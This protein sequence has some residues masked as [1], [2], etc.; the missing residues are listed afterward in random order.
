MAKLSASSVTVSFSSGCTPVG[1]SALF[2]RSQYGGRFWWSDDQGQVVFLHGWGANDSAYA[3]SSPDIRSFQ[4][5][6]RAIS[7]DPFHEGNLLAA[8]TTNLRRARASSPA[9]HIS[10][11][12]SVQ[13]WLSAISLYDKQKITRNEMVGVDFNT[14]TFTHSIRFSYL[15]FQNQI[16]DATTGNSSLPFDNL[17]AEIFMGATGLVAGPNLLAPQSTPQSDHEFKYDGSRIWGA[18]IIRFGVAYNHLHGGGF[19]SFFRNGPQIGTAVLPS[20]VDDRSD[21]ACFPGGAANPFNYPADFATLTNELGYSFTDPALGFPAGGLGPDN[22]VLLYLGDTWKIKSNFSLTYGLRY[23]RDTGRT[24]SQFPAIPQ[25]SALIPGLG[26]PVSQPNTNFAPQVGFAW[27]PTKSGKTSIRGGIGLFFEN[28]IW[29]N[30]LFDGPPRE[31]TGA[32]LQFFG[33]CSAPGQ[34]VQLQTVNGPINTQGSAS[35]TAICGPQGASTY[36]LIGNAVAPLSLFSSNLPLVL[37]STCR[38][39]IRPTLDNT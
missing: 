39:R 4:A 1:R 34:P 5:P 23:E 17:G 24:D 18:H 8:S 28:A 3:D 29:N 11:T 33:P 6:T 32:F 9:I 7:A 21:R 38:R 35:A 22:R 2:Q 16:V 10:R 12:N 30:V 13:L 25:L 26:N 37:P 14:G 31:K 27:D 15:K 36:P 19:A 20:E